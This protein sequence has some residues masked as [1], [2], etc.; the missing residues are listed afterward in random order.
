MLNFKRLFIPIVVVTFL[1]I[2]YGIHLY[3]ENFNTKR[4]VY[5]PDKMKQER[6]Y[7]GLMLDEVKSYKYKNKIHLSFKLTNTLNETFQ[8]D[9]LMVVFIDENGNVADKYNFSINKLNINENKKIDIVI[10]EKDMEQYNFLIA[11]Q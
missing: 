1:F 10:N 4:S 11:K 8:S 2:G 3:N 9:K 5:V 6:K 7:Y